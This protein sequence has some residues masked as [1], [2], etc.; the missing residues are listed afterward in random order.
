MKDELKAQIV[1]SALRK[2]VPLLLT[3]I[4]EEDEVKDMPEEIL[5][6]FILSLSVSFLLNLIIPHC[7][8]HLSD[9]EI[10]AQCT[11]MI[12][13]IHLNFLRGLNNET[14]K[15]KMTRYTNKL[16]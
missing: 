3:C 8:P 1:E 5:S 2:L 10:N 4:I 9:T 11:R 12:K 13:G 14:M 7:N 6:D 16:H 15:D